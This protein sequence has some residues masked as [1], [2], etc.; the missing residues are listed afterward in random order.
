MVTQPWTLKWSC[1]CYNAL[2]LLYPAE[3]RVRFGREMA[4]VFMDCCRDEAATGGSGG[5]ALVGLRAV[6]DLV[7]SIPR[8]RGRALLDAG[9]L[10]GPVTGMI[11]SIVILMI[12]GF[13]LFAGG[14]AIAAYMGQQYRTP[15][16]FV[17]MATLY[18][19][20]LG[21]VGIACSLILSRF[22]R[23]HY[24]VIEL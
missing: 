22:R 24:R 5:I 18:G 19:T 17:L 8:E 10:Q 4:Q 3:F 1:R 21:G 6:M 23:I 12:I 20:A 14:T 2:L 13:H 7:L 15:A 9:D 16:D 11:D